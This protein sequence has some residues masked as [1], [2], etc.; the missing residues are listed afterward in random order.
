MWRNLALVLYAAVLVLFTAVSAP[1]AQFGTAEEAKAMLDRA[2]AAVTQD[3]TKALEMFNKGEGGFKDRDL[4]VACANASDGIVTAHPT[5]KGK[6]LRDIL[7][8]K[9]YPL[10]QEMMQKAT[11]GT[12]REITYWWPR[13]GSD[14]PLE[15]TSFYT[16]VGDQI[17]SVGYYKE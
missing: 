6:Q 5:M 9:G 15:K 8:K 2:V 11:E 16:K 17:C 10:G 14:K 13:P 1:A 4:Y 12:I 7:G 3:K